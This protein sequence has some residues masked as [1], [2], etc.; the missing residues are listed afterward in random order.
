MSTNREVAKRAFS[1][2]DTYV[3]GDYVLSRQRKF[4]VASK[5]K[6]APMWLEIRS[7]G[8][9]ITST[10][11]DEA[12]EGQSADY[13]EL[14]RRCIMEIEAADV[15]I[16]YCEAGEILKGAMIEAGAALAFGKPVHCVGTCDSL[17]R[18]FN[19]HPLWRRC[20]NID[21]AIALPSPPPHE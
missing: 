18:V 5:V 7:Q 11:I 17:S 14:S 16:L 15:V 1:D 9:Q 12:G 13:S 10:W 21:E 4:Y 19:R 6:H 2:R 3:S 8:R 20:R